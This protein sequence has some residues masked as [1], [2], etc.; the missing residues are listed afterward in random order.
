MAE[1]I[2]NAF[3]GDR[4]E[5]YSA[6]I[7]PTAVN[8]YVIKVVMEV[9]IDISKNHAKNLKE[10]YGK[11]FDYVVTVCDHAKEVCPFFPGEI[12]LHQS[13]DDP[14]EFTGSEEKIM[15]RVR[16]V[17]TDIKAWI[18]KTFNKKSLKLSTNR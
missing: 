2:L 11:H 7:E 3:F 13:F 10:F 1:G 4:Y 14:S 15:E 17:R 8:P 9:G 12:I 18:E 16:R 5:E 6:E